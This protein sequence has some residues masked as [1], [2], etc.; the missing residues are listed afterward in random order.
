M[1]PAVIAFITFV[2]TISAIAMLVIEGQAISTNETTVLNQIMSW[3]Q[4]T[5]YED[6]T[7]LQ[8]F[9]MIQQFGEGLFRLITL[10]FPQL[11][12][13]WELL[14][15]IVWGPIIAYVVYGLVILF[16]GFFQKNV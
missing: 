7:P 14:R 11:S 5:S 13:P 9:G 2:W 4:V 10:D 8:F 1:A 15:L 3:Q 16:I 12:G 6:I